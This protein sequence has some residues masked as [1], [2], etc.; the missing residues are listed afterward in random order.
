LN[1]RDSQSDLLDDDLSHL[2][3]DHFSAEL[4]QHFGR[5][6][7]RFSMAVSPV[8]VAPKRTS[9]FS[10]A[11]WWAAP[12]IAAAAVVALFAAPQLRTVAP[13]NSTPQKSVA[14][15]PI[16]PNANDSSL[17]IQANREV[18]FE[19]QDVTGRVTWAT[20][21][22]GQVWLDDETPARKYRKRQFE[23]L[24]YTDPRDLSRIEVTV[25][26]D[27]IILVSSPRI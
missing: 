10:T 14:M 17:P 19:P 27:E 5:A 18:E 6:A 24:Q 15:N 13:V 7:E 3:R 12:V 4:D 9:G 23:T 26:R 20:R 22:E 25:P 21:D 16:A 1:D 8:D 11:A 2:L